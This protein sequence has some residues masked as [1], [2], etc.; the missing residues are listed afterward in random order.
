MGVDLTRPARIGILEADELYQD[1]QADYVSYGTMFIRLFRGLPGFD[2]RSWT[3]Q[4]YQIL[5][6]EWPDP[7]NPCDAYLITGSK[8]GVYDTDLWIAKLSRWIKQE[9][10]NQTPLLGVCFGHQILAHSLGGNAGLCNRGWGVGVRS[11][12]IIDTAAKAI[13]D[14]TPTVSATTESKSIDAISLIYSH[15]DQVDLLPP[16]AQLLLGDSFCPNAAFMIPNRVLAFQGHPEFTAEYLQRLLPRRED[17]IGEQRLHGG[18]DS[19]KRATDEQIIGQW[20][21]QFCQSALVSR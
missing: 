3:F 14:A 2:E 1:L 15:Q 6:D 7:N 16:K 18:L 5:K 17:S 9:F 11:T 20:M 8:S 19:L 13:I 21:L 4:H 10:N 12:P